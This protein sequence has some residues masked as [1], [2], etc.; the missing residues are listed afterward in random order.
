MTL[1][2]PTVYSCSGC[3]S[4][5]QMAN[6]L[7]IQLDRIGEAQMSC[8]AGVGGDVG[9]LVRAAKNSEFI[10][11]IDGCPLKCCQAC[12]RKHQLKAKMQIVLSDYKIE[13]RLHQDFSQEEA[14]HLLLNIRERLKTI[15]NSEGNCE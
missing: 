4:A 9:S 2:I 11:T 15:R 14:K 6:H 8:I 12:L 3:S 1:K 7:A 5:A 10:I 13:R